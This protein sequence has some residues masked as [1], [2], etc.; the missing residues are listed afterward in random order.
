MPQDQRRKPKRVVITHVGT[1]ALECKA[2]QHRGVQPTDYQ[3]ELEDVKG[4]RRR[5]DLL[6]K[7]G[8]ALQEGLRIRWNATNYP[9][10]AERRKASPAEIASLSMLGLEAGDRIVLV[11]SDTNA[12]EFCALLLQ[13][14][15]LEQPA[16]DLNAV[17]RV[18]DV[19]I[20]MTKLP[21][22]EMEDSSQFIDEGLPAYMRLLTNEIWDKEHQ[23]AK[24][25]S[26]AQLIFNITGGLKGVVPFAVLAAQLIATH[27]DRHVATRIAYAHEQG[28]DLISLAPLLPINWLER[29]GLR[30]LYPGIR[31]LVESSGS[32]QAFALGDEFNAYKRVPG[33]PN[34][35]AKTVHYLFSDL[36]WQ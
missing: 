29:Y 13:Q 23:K 20:G 34:A 36:D 1:S 17:F 28:K 35:L 32:P 24:L 25:D 30:D 6:P 10:P 12:G 18:N 26:E 22:V 21:K 7:W 19:D 16:P 5:L 14:C 15:L 27:P 9:D 3:N 4:N 2:I 8:E 11:Y 31:T 33:F